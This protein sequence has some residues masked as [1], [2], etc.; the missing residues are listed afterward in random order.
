MYYDKRFQYDPHFPLINH[1][2]IKESTC[3]TA[4]YLLAEKSKFLSDY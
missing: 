2:Q 3:T 1:E 4:G